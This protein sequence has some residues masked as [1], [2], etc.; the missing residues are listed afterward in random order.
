M[1]LKYL[2]LQ[3]KIES[4]EKEI[5]IVDNC[6]GEDLMPYIRKYQK[7]NSKTIIRYFRNYARLGIT[8]TRNV[9][10]FH[11]EGQFLF[12]LDSDIILPP[13]TIHQ[14]MLLHKTHHHNLV[15]SRFCD[16]KQQLYEET[17]HMLKASTYCPIEYLRNHL[18]EIWNPYLETREKILSNRKVSK[19]CM[20]VLGACFCMS[21]PKQAFLSIGGFDSK[22]IGWGAEEIDFTYRAYQL[23]MELNV[24][25]EAVCYHLDDGTRNLN[26]YV[27]ARSKNFRYLSKKYSN[28]EMQACLQF[29]DGRISYEEFEARM[30]RKEFSEEEEKTFHFIRNL[31]YIISK[32]TTSHV[33]EQTSE[34]HYSKKLLSNE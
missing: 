18:Q 11:S 13:R 8:A 6:S 15:M 16:L 20:W 25:N 34:L 9:G 3:E 5:I 32:L 2:F 7:K 28:R 14:H 31:N 12:F 21:M 24:C 4:V 10:A 22:L 23:G 19:H 30:E 29:L 1:T 26:E 33:E 17:I 27:R